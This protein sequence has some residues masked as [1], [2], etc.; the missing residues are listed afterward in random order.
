[1]LCSVPFPP[2]RRPV[3]LFLNLPTATTYSS[4]FLTISDYVFNHC[5][6]NYANNWSLKWAPGN[7][8]LRLLGSLCARA[9]PENHIESSESKST[10]PRWRKNYH[11]CTPIM[12]GGPLE[13]Y[14]WLNCNNLLMEACFE[15]IIIECVFGYFGFLQF[16][17]HL[18]ANIL[19]HLVDCKIVSEVSYEASKHIL[20]N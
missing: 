1:M 11:P 14:D 9:H 17:S 5:L 18:N 19:L 6:A 8:F 13:I 16:Y 2:C 10:E 15:T 20:T 12:Y 4:V 3:F 7:K